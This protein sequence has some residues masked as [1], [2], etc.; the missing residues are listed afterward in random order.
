MGMEM[1]MGLSIPKIDFRRLRLEKRFVLAKLLE[2]ALIFIDRKRSAH[3]EEN[4]VFQILL[5]HFSL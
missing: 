5:E 4:K 2:L 1:E 3:Q